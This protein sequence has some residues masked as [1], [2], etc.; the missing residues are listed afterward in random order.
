MLSGCDAVGWMFQAALGE[1]G[2]WAIVRVWGSLKKEGRA[3]GWRT[4][5][6]V[7]AMRAWRSRVFR[8]PFGFC[9]GV[10]TRFQAAY[11]ASQ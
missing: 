10:P 7:L 2:A 6:L 9:K 1:G 3:A 11:A 5:A 8:L 4:F